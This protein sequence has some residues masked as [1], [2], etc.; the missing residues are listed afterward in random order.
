[1]NDPAPFIITVILSVLIGFALG[2]FS[3]QRDWINDCDLIQQH[4]AGK[5]AFTCARVQP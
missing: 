5:T 4:R 2:G 1:M 3:E